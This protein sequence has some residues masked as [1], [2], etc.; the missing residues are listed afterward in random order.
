MTHHMNSF[1]VLM[2]N[3]DKALEYVNTAQ[4]ASGESMTKYEAYTDSLAGKI[5]LYIQKCMYRTYLIAGN[6]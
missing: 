3:F 4:N 5:C 6:A 1:M 2:Q